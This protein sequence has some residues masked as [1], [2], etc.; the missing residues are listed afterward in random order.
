MKYVLDSSVALKWVLPEPDSAK[1]LELRD[2]FAKGVHELLTPDIFL[3]ET[4][5]ALTKAERQRKIAFGDAYPLWQAILIDCPDLHPHGPLLDRA[6]QVASAARH[7]VYDCV[8][9]ALAEREGCEFVTADE[10]LVKK[11]KSS[12][13]FITLLTAL[14]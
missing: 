9:L 5:H 11:L 7:S 10:K 8:Y 6:A 4:L 2:E 13:S 12:F 14:P 3:L 1:A